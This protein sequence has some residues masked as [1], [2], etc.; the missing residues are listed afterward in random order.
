MLEVKA[1]EGRRRPRTDKSQTINSQ[2]QSLN[3]GDKA[4]KV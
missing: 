1:P 2:T 3:I 4:I